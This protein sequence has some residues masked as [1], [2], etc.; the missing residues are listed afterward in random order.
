MSFALQDLHLLLLFRGFSH[1]TTR[2]LG[3]FGPGFREVLLARYMGIFDCPACLP[4]CLLRWFSI[5]KGLQNTCTVPRALYLV[6][7]RMVM[8]DTASLWNQQQQLS[9][10]FIPAFL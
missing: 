5:M 6:F 10:C 1:G 8:R 4:A 3:F 9:Y 7:W 2:H